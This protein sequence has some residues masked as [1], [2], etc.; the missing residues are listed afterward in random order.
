MYLSYM[1]VLIHHVSCA[2]TLRDQKR[3]LDPLELELVGV[4]CL[5]QVLEIQ[6]RSSERAVSDYNY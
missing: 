5:I 3:V 1:Y 6:T 2:G 4:S